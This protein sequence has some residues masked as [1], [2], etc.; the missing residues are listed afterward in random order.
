[1]EPLQLL[2][3]LMGLLVA[4][5]GVLMLFRM[6]RESSANARR[7]Y[8]PLGTAAVGL[9]IAYR[10]FS[11]FNVLDAQDVM[12][13][14]VFVFGLL[15]LLGLQFFIVDHHNP[16]SDTAVQDKADDRQAPHVE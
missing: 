13:M 1:M 16:N 9:I 3:I 11:A 15:A 5:A 6:S 14:F 12:I 4:G 8:I 7:P 10:A 2:L